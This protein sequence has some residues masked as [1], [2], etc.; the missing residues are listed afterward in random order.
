LIKLKYD[1]NSIESLNLE[2][3][4]FIESSDIFISSKRTTRTEWLYSKFNFKSDTAPMLLRFDFD[5]GDEK[6]EG[7]IKESIADCHPKNEECI[8][9]TVDISLIKRSSIASIFA[10]I[11]RASSKRRVKLNIIYTLAK[12]IKPEDDRLP[13][14]DVV[15]PVHEMFSGW[16]SKPGLPVMTIVGLGYE[17][18]KAIGAVEYLESSGCF[19]FIP[20]S[21]ESDYYDQVVEKN[22]DL[23]QLINDQDKLEYKVLEP[24]QT[25][26]QIDSLL[27]S[28]KTSNK[29]VLLPF[30]P[31]IF[32]ACSLLAAVANPEVAVWNACGNEKRSLEYQDRE[33]VTYAGL[34]CTISRF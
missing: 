27:A 23:I 29:V 7:S 10:E 2:G 15:E 18:G 8:E 25:L 16:S 3:E 5:E 28:K 30:G 9:I 20:T 17:R 4:K 34:A 21:P 22:E 12:F 24:I 19:L 26:Y 6:V 32:Y 11:F 13:T 31:K 33:M 1:I 14:T